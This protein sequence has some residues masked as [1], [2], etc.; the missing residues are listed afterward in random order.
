IERTCFYAP[1]S[2]A[3]PSIEV[4]FAFACNTGASWSLVKDSARAAGNNNKT[5]TPRAVLA[6]LD[7]ESPLTRSAAKS[8]VAHEMVPDADI[9][10][11]PYMADLTGRIKRAWIPPKGDTRRIIAVFKIY[12]DG[13]ISDLRLDRS[14]GSALADQAALNAIQTAAPFQALPDGAP[15]D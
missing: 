7:L 8:S 15:P 4:E 12:E 14:S 11:G 10:F 9:D 3:P 13:T 2:G 6:K 1:P 5:P